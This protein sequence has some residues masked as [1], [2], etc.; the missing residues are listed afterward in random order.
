MSEN[1][2]INYFRKL[3]KALLQSAEAQDERAL[4]RWRAVIHG[5]GPL[6]L[7]KAQAIIAREHGFVSW[8]ELKDASDIELRLAITMSREPDLNDFGIGLY[9]DHQRRPRAERIQRLEED[10][11][12]LRDSVDAVTTTVDW[13]RERVEPIRSINMKHTSYG[14]KHLAEKDVGYIT[15][16]VFIAAAIV[17]GYPYKIRFDSPNVCFGMSERSISR[18]CER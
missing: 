5:S 14:L 7:M 11:Q 2:A 4:H 10:R 18:I 9:H 12:Q 3:A 15:N 8:D 1:S 17:A 16:G 6:V 13:L